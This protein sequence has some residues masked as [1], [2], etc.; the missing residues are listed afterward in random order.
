MQRNYRTDILEQI[1]LESSSLNFEVF[2]AGTPL[3]CLGN[4][5][6][7]SGDGDDFNH[8]DTFQAPGSGDDII[9]SGEGDDDNTGDNIHFGPGT[10]NDIILSGEGDD[11]NFGDTRSGGTEARGFGDDIIVSGGGDDTN[12][13]NG[14]GDIFACGGGDDTVTDYN[15]AEGDIAGPD[16]ENT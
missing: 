10:G 6:I 4:D 8:G 16:C 5:V 3:L 15:E 9:L 1:G 12:T 13:G 11:E 14:G 7:N 2:S